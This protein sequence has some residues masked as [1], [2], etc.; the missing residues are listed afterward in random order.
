MAAKKPTAV[1]GAPEELTGPE[2]ETLDEHEAQVAT[3][4]TPAPGMMTAA[5]GTL[6][7]AIAP[8]F[9]LPAIVQRHVS[10]A[11]PDAMPRPLLHNIG[12]W[13][14]PDGEVYT[15]RERR[16]GQ[17][18]FL[19]VDVKNV[20]TDKTRRIPMTLAK[21]DD[22]DGY[23]LR[24]MERVEARTE[25]VCDFEDHMIKF[26][27]AFG[28]EYAGDPLGRRMAAKGLRYDDSPTPGLMGPRG[29]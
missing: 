17:F 13:V 24:G 8:Q 28:D 12:V 14:W 22:V 26:L 23:G 2:P 15:P 9:N 19:V 21:K 4:A 11:F 18:S 27:K 25:V 6:V 5:P 29:Q 7:P 3:L 16:G 20:V 10:E 1:Q